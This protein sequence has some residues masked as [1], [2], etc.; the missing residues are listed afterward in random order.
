[1]N[2]IKIGIG[3]EALGLPLRRALLEAER[4]G[5]AGVEA[6]AIGEL[7]PNQLS[8]TGRR[9][10]L[11]LLRGHNLALTA[12]RCPLRRGLDSAENQEARIDHVKKV[13]SL[14]F[15][16]GPRVVVV[17][18]GKVP[19]GDDDPRAP[20]LK[21]ALVALA[22][23]GDRVGATLA[24]ETGLESGE[25]LANYLARF[26]T[27]SLGA[28]FDPANLLLNGFSP[29]EGA[30]ALAGRIVHAH[31]RDARRAGPSRAAQ[32][33]PLGLGDID[34]MVLAGV[35]EE[36][37][38]RGWMAVQRDGGNRRREDVAAGVAFLRRILG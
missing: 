18:A 31:A 3:L 26:D 34:W 12:L 15:D 11:H 28:N 38:Y 4:L 1:M 7:T 36:V 25:A 23:H 37:E 9:E 19:E 2:K 8:Q 13:L 6:E 27:G 5:V 30:R 10:F 22:A 29:Y 14:S 24:L 21:D 17:Q 33:V 16:L 32:E 35:L 20:L